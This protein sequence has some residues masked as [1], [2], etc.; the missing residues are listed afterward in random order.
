MDEHTPSQPLPGQDS[1]LHN[2]GD[3]QPQIAVNPGAEAPIPAEAAPAQL[4]HSTEVPPAA[5]AIAT[6]ITTTSDDATISNGTDQDVTMQDVKQ[7]K[8]VRT[9]YSLHLY[10]CYLHCV[11]VAASITPA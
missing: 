3:G 8:E 9:A 5:A 2:N 11:R 4:P 10:P 1:A 7:E 6:T